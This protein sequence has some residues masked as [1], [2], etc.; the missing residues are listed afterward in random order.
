MAV[1]SLN[2]V[3]KYYNGEVVLENITFSVNKNDKIAIVG[4]NGVGKT[5]LLKIINKTIEADSGFIYYEDASSIGYLSQKVISNPE[6]TLFEEMELAFS[7]LKKIEKEMELSLKILDKSDQQ[8]INYYSDLEE[9]YNNLGGYEYKY[10]IEMLLNKFGFDKSFYNRKLNSFS[11][12]EKTRASLV[13][14]LLNNPSILLLDEPTNHLDLV[15]I[16][17]LEKY[18][19]TYSGTI[20]IV[21]HDQTFIDHM[22]NKVLE[23]ENHHAT[24]YPGNFTYYSQEKVNRYQQQLKQYNLQEKEIKR[25]EMLIAKFKPKPTKT[26]FAQ[27]LE[28]KLS[29][30]EKIEKPN[31]YKKNIKAS[32]KTSLNHQV[33]MHKIENLQ[34][35]FNKIPLTKPFSLDIYNGDKVVIMGQNGSGKTTLLKCIINNTN[36]ISGENYKVRDYSYFYFDQ[37]Q[38]LLDEN[39]TLF[40]TIQ[41]E[42]PLMD[43]SQ[44]RSL[45][46]RFLFS[47]DD[48]F[49]LVKNLSGGEKIRLIFALITLKDYQ[50][51]FLDE[52]TNHLDFT[53]KKILAEILED[54][55]GCIIM[56]SHDRYFINKVVNK[57]IYLQNK[58]YIFEN[59]NYDDFLQKHNLESNDFT[60]L[61]KN[62]KTK[63]VVIKN[64]KKENSKLINKIEKEIESLEKKLNEINEKLYDSE[65]EYDWIEYRSFE[66][67]SQK[68]EEKLQEL[69]Y[70]LDSLEQ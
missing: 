25:Y 4:D 69:L 47:D 40:D 26:S 20:I 18:L 5:T 30:M 3:S 36:Y 64:E 51:L 52:P 39:K 66:E 16:E 24:L 11:G 1:L 45:L 35:G 56:V 27:S 68:I 6:N 57:V 12:G 33:L 32:F 15:M 8:T 38:E 2:N 61:L 46:G 41:D 70:K 10:K 21:T 13:K 29:K 44:V 34:F 60:A 65:K 23:I 17:W 28:K 50:V 42:Y 54:Y 62:S 59:G 53:T 14:L 63:K 55:Q 7:K 67:E 37:N 19:N 9:K 58:D 48:V 49:K 31:N 43:N 22:A